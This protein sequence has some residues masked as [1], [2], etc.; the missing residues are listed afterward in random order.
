MHPIEWSCR[1]QKRVVR[2]TY[3]AELHSVSD[4]IETALVIR[5][6]Y[7]QLMS[8]KLLNALEL[9][10][11]IVPPLQASIDC[12]SVF[13]SLASEETKRPSEESLIF[14][15]L[16]LKELLRH[17]KL[18]RMWWVTTGDMLAD[19]MNKGVVSRQYLLKTI[20]SG[21]WSLLNDTVFHE[22]THA[23]SIT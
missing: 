23:V 4:A 16:Q 14:T 2:S 8:T 19:C 13:D 3:G 5:S 10:N 22:E 7:A 1:K 12:R 15:L 9:A 6:V 20:H 17:K 21:T 11:C 18:E